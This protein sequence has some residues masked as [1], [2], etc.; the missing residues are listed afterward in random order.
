M[1]FMQQHKKMLGPLTI[2][3]VLTQSDILHDY[4]F[5]TSII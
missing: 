2:R 5:L 1:E 3:K 4:D